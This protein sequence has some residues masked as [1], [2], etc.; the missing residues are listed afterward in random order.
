MLPALDGPAR[1]WKATGES[2]GGRLS[3]HAREAVRS[4]RRRTRSFDYEHHSSSPS[5]KV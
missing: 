5:K 2:G 1:V 3:D 4:G